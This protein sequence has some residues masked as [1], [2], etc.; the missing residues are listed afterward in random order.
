[1]SSKYNEG[2]IEGPEVYQNCISLL[3]TSVSLCKL[4]I[5]K[6]VALGFLIKLVKDQDDFFCLMTNENIIKEDLIAKKESFQFYFDNEKKTREIKLD[7]EERYS[8]Y[9]L[10]IRKKA[11][12]SIL[13][14]CAV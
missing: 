4:V 14:F 11:I 6:K 3:Q 9:I 12:N 2:K 13:Y 8:K 10:I 7:P 5:N 1:M